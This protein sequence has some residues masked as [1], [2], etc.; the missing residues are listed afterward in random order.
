MTPDS[1]N[2]RRLSTLRAAD[3]RIPLKDFL[4]RADL[5]NFRRNP[6]I[7]FDAETH[8]LAQRVYGAKSAAP[9]RVYAP[10]KLNSNHRDSRPSPKFREGDNT[11]VATARRSTR[12][13]VT[14]S[15]VSEMGS[16]LST[17]PRANHRTSRGRR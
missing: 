13:E 2:L 4:R 15:L 5:R 17:G 6:P 10:I 16:Y 9:A 1:P 11:T 12:D 14:R 7:V 3:T 8:A